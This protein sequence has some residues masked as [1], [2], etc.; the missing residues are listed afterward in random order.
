MVLKKRPGDEEAFAMKQFVVDAFADEIFRGNPAAV[1]T[2]DAWPSE[3]LM[4]SVARENRF[5]ETA[6]VVGKGA[7][8][9]L[10]WFTPGGE[11]DLC[12]HATLA[13]AFVLFQF[14][15]RDHNV[16]V[17]ETKS[18]DLTVARRRDGKIE[19]E[20]PAYKPTRIPVAPGIV[21]ALGVEPKEVWRARD[22]LCVF[23]DEAIVRNI[24]PDLKKVKALDAALVHVTAPGA[25]SDCVSRSFAPKFGVDEDSACGSGHCLIAPYWAARL[26]K[27]ELVAYQASERGATLYCRVVG[28]KVFLAGNAALFSMGVICAK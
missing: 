24:A 20:F 13:S 26:G 3:K 22:L 14:D 10:R 25:D 1:C 11:I 7:K 9:K 8:R 15:E 2:T 19:M 16:L 21:D 5:S 27:P 12:G 23:D 28:D 17:F 18:G 4:T 6:F